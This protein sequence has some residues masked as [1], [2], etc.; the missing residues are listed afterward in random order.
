LAQSLKKS[1]FKPSA[2]SIFDAVTND[3]SAFVK[4]YVQTDDIT[5]MV[6]KYTGDESAKNKVKL[7]ISKDQASAELKNKN[8]SWN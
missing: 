3:F 2:E 4:E 1:G 5:M 8:W 6:I 7:T